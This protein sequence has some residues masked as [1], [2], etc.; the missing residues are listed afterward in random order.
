MLICFD[1]HRM[2]SICSEQW[3]ACGVRQTQTHKYAFCL[4]RATDAEKKYS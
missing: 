2:Y 4:K 1:I 3:I